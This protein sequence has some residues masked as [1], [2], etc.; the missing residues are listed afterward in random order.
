MGKSVFQF[1]GTVVL[2]IVITGFLGCKTSDNRK[3]PNQASIGQANTSQPSQ[4]NT[5]L[6]KI[7]PSNIKTSS[8][9]DKKQTS[10]PNKEDNSNLLLGNPSNAKTDVNAPNNYLV[11]KKQYTLSYDDSEKTPNWV[12]WHVNSDDLGNASREDD[13]REDNT[14]PATWDKVDSTGYKNSGFDRGHMCPS[15]DRTSSKDNN[16]ATFFMDNMIPQAPNNNRITWVKLESYTRKLVK[17][18]NEVY[19]IAGTY[20]KGGTGSK[21]YKTTI[22]NGIVVPSRIWKVVIILENGDNDIKRINSYTRVIAVS[23]PNNQDCANKSWTDYRVSVDSIESSTGYDFLSNVP[24][25]IQ[26]KIESR[27]DN[28]PV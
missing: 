18:N 21:G 14:L 20:G 22:G 10:L 25:S 6:N 28:K 17:K 27:V 8:Q 9:K 3:Q 24:V 16:S 19:I 23:I 12:S 15:A 11:L 5:D 2:M 7:S 26:D 1:I 13:F 4:T